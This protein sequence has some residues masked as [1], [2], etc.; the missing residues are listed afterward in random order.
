MI[1][2]RI[3]CP[4]KAAILTSA[5]RFALEPHFSPIHIWKG[6]RGRTGI[7]NLNSPKKPRSMETLSL[8]LRFFSALTK[9]SNLYTV[10]GNGGSLGLAPCARKISELNVSPK[11]LTM[12]S[13]KSLPEQVLVFGHFVPSTSNNGHDFS[14]R[15]KFFFK[16]SSKL[17][18]TSTSQDAAIDTSSPSNMS[19]VL[20]L[21][22]ASVLMVV[23]NCGPMVRLSVPFTA[24]SYSFTSTDGTRDRPIV[25]SILESFSNLKDGAKSGSLKL[26][27]SFG[28]TSAV[29]EACPPP[30]PPTLNFATPFSEDVFTENLPS[31]LG[32]TS[33]KT[34]TGPMKNLN[35]F[36][37]PS[38]RFFVRVNSLCPNKVK[39]KP[40]E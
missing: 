33:N 25:N 3:A 27:Y 5:C 17:V 16:P 6:D 12:L 30:F 13:K 14:K 2:S 28:G 19:H 22:M 23:S 7:F 36:F 4:R 15:F 10:L 24:P 31:I 35:P 21:K 38:Q 8:P 34:G 39:S 9:S 1:V 11:S 40:A 37:G 20:P 26:V 29:T 18:P 32:C